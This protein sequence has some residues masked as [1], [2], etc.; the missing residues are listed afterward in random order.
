MAHYKNR[1]NPAK[2]AICARCEEEDETVK[3]WIKCPASMRLRESIFGRAD[4]GL[5]VISTHPKETLAYAEKS[6]LETL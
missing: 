2:S 4:L 6:M 5:D 1:I 3:H